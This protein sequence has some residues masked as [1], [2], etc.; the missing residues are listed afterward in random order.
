M[1]EASSLSNTS[2]HVNQ[3]TRLHALLYINVLDKTRSQ[4]P[5]LPRGPGNDVK[6]I[7]LTTEQ[8][9]LQ[10]KVMCN[11]SVQTELHENLSTA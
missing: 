10:G 6:L 2:V 7:L 3:T 5:T 1:T 8:K 4:K 11:G 9:I